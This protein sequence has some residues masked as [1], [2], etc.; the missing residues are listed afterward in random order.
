[1]LISVWVQG[2]ETERLQPTPEYST[3]EEWEGAKYPSFS[4]S[5][6][7]P[8]YTIVFHSILKSYLETR[9]SRELTVFYATELSRVKEG[10][11]ED[12]YVTLCKISEQLLGDNWREVTMV[13]KNNNPPKMSRTCNYVSSYCKK[14]LASVIKLRILRWRDYPGLP[15]RVQWN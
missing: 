1:M 8:S 14:I 11:V 4:L 15:R 9:R 6:A 10:C 7:L 12:H 13:N 2:L 3:E 5:Q